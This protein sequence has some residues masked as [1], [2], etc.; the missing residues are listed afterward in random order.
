MGTAA[1]LDAPRQFPAVRTRERT[2]TRLSP[3]RPSGVGAAPAVPSL[4]PEVLDR[5]AGQ[6]LNSKIANEMQET[7]GRGFAD[8]RVHTDGPAAQSAAAIG[9]DAFT[10]VSDI[11]FAAGKYRPDSP[12]GAGL[13]AHELTHVV[14]QAGATRGHR[15]IV[16][17]APADAAEREAGSV[18]ASVIT[19]RDG[20]N[21][22]GQNLLPPSRS[23][24]TP[25]LPLGP[26]GLAARS[27]AAGVVQ[28]QPAGPAATTQ[29][30]APSAI[31]AGGRP[32]GA[33]KWQ[34]DDRAQWNQYFQLALQGTAQKG[35]SQARQAALA[36]AVA[37]MAILLHNR[38][39]KALRALI[40]GPGIDPAAKTELDIVFATETGMWADYFKSALQ[41]TAGEQDYTKADVPV[42]KA[43]RLADHAAL[44]S[45][46][47]SPENWQ[48]YMTALRQ[49]G[50]PAASAAPAHPAS[51]QP[52]PM[53]PGP[54]LLPPRG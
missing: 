25:P 12:A 29:P 32:A 10:V 8:V 31:T 3:A 6:P 46:A 1:K 7:F 37:D 17:G 42:E 24:G 51:P 22:R 36:S 41:T 11:I 39:G 43:I 44:Q 9:A 33:Q 18:A 20:H 26:R 38:R 21:S 27:A 34:A 45:G 53:L 50:I 28:R 19:S 48:L 16:L 23:P 5:R 47:V 13:I 4:I 49:A 30:G 15:G 35:T 40:D 2:P 54:R 52:R 14:Q